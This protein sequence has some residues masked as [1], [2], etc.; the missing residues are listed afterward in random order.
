MSK[1][2]WVGFPD[3]ADRTDGDIT[4]G[5]TGLPVGLDL[6]RLQ[7]NTSVIRRGVIGWGGYDAVI[8][9]AFEGDSD[10]YS[11]GAT[12]IDASGVGTSSATTSVARA[13]MSNYNSMN[14]T[15][16]NSLHLRNGTLA[17][18]WNIN[19]LNSRIETHEQYDP[20]VRA[21]QFN[22][23]IKKQ[24]LQAVVAHNT[25][26]ALEDTPLFFNVLLGGTD[27]YF[28]FKVVNTLLTS[29]DVGEVG[30]T[31]VYRAIAMLVV[32]GLS[33]LRGNSFDETIDDTFFFSARPTRAAIAVGVLTS[34]KL[35]RATPTKNYQ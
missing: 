1:E 9:S 8:L 13:E 11:V 16:R 28:V 30:G 4:V 15:H 34:A 35:V 32:R 17:L 10:E 3:V 31:M 2:S 25:K 26:E 27:A 23:E 21:K 29:G 14:D 24:A 5:Y 20:K 7:L 22:K 12:G 18:R 33:T 6:E 19:A